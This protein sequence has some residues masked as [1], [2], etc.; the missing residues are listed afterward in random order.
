MV[1]LLNGSYRG[2][3]S[4]SNYFLGLLE[5]QLTKPCERVHINKIK[6]FDLLIDKLISADALVLGM[7]LYVDGVPAQVVELMEY[8]YD[9]KKDQ[10][11]NLSVYVLSNLGFYESQQI[12]IQLE[13][14]KNWCVK[15]GM[16]Y[17]GGLAI[18]AGGMMGGLRNVPYD[19]GP[20]KMMGNGIKTLAGSIN[21]NDSIEDIYVQPTAF[22]RLLYFIAANM[23]WAPKAKKNGL[24]RRDI[25]IRK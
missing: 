13:I 14:V 19:Q 12:R 20:N 6:S 21:S 23:S 4:N 16:I 3:D 7:P 22:P 24:K 2:E 18:G 8:L 17:G 5:T 9:N 25:K 15:M 11:G 10:L 1:I